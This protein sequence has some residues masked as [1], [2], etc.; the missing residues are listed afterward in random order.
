MAKNAL[1]LSVR[2]RFAKLIF[3]GSK[4]VEL[5]RLR[6]RVRRGDLVF[7]YVPSPIKALQGV[8]EVNDVLSASTRSVWRRFGAQTG[9]SKKEFDAYFQGKQTACAIL[10]GRFWK[11]KNPV[12]LE[13]LKK[14]RNGFHPPQ[15]HHYI[16]PEA[17][18]R[19]VGFRQMKQGRWISLTP[20]GNQSRES[21]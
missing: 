11:F 14:D 1:V 6:P 20:S 8:F 4:I 7:V 13:K 2:V 18:S 17:F 19:S 10:I 21:S 16:C 5:R 3:S 15:S 12:H 9:L